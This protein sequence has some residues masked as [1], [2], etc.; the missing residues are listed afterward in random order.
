MEEERE[1]GKSVGVDE[2]KWVYDSSVDYKGRVPLRAST[3][4]WKA[5]LFIIVIEF[6]E[7]LSYFGI[8]ASLIIYLTS[9]IHQDLK[10]AAKSSNYWTGV[11]TVMPLLGGFL[12]DAYLGRFSTVLASSIVYLLGLILLTMSRLVPALKPCDASNCQE[13]RKIHEVIFF[14]AIY[15]ISIGTG[16]HKPSLQS[17][18]ADQFDNDH[19]QERIKKMSFFNWWNFG[20]CSGLLLGVT[21]IVYIQDHVSWA[22]ADIVL[23]AVMTGSIVVFC[24]GRLF[25]RY[26]K[27]MG[28]PLTPLLHVLVAAI[29]KRKLVYPS[30]TAELYEVSKTENNE[31]LLCHTHKLKFLDKAAIV[32]DK[33]DSNLKQQSPWRLATVTKV[34]ELKLVLNMIPI[35]LATLPFGICVAQ[36]ST[37]FIKQ[38]TM[39]DRKIGRSFLIPPASLYALAAIGMIISVLLYE[40][41]LL[42]F[43]RKATGNER[44]VKILQ[45]IGF[46]MI[47]SVVTMIVAAL[48]ERKR[49]GLVEKNPLKGSTTMSV[50]WL[51]PQFLI[52]GFGDGFALVGLQ[53]YFYDQ[54]PYSMRSLGIAF[55]LSV[56][57]VANFISSL[58]I[59]IV[60]HVTEN[61]GK[62]WFG[63]DLNNSRLD[64]FYWLLA[65]ITAVNLSGYVVL[66]RQYSY[67]NEQGRG[68]VAVVDCYEGG[69]GVGTMA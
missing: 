27:P 1:R 49:L 4:V 56:I 5:S 47:F 41:V 22:V 20:L 28:S 64:N 69:D 11:T 68:A 39:L 12:A 17:F 8:V 23:T 61:M 40:K 36:S 50:F 48:V 63:K 51:A 54:V 58:L 37:F 10:T 3:G 66:A 55:Y 13:P 29:S 42:P 43:L 44:G 33:E 45:R 67:K 30:N 62:S 65:I 35:W 31:R 60:D 52:I 53:E 14:L 6:S 59:T 57:G 16:G 7:R 2:E 18:G 19:H 34:E 9:V 26:R 32:E 25:Y 46:G 38:G 15:L 21:V 24:T